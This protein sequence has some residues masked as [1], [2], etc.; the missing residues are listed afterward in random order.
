[1]LANLK[2]G[3]KMLSAFLLVAL[4]TALVGGI[5]VL[6]IRQIDVA[7]QIHQVAT[8]AEEQTATTNEISSNIVQITQVV[9]QTSQGAQESALA[10]A[11]LHTNS[12]ELQQLVQQF[13]L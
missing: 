6:K 8:A 5:G 12:E 7:M 9:Q 11:Q 10:A 2:V 13:R 1:M 4:I 3:T